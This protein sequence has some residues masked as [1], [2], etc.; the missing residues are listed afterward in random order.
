LLLATI[1]CS[2]GTILDTSAAFNSKF[3]AIE[4]GE[5]R[6]IEGELT[7]EWVSALLTDIANIPLGEKPRGLLVGIAKPTLKGAPWFV[8]RRAADAGGGSMASHWETTSR[9][10]GYG[11]ESA[12]AHIPS[13]AEG[14]TNAGAG[15]P[16]QVSNAGSDST[17]TYDNIIENPEPATLGLCAAAM[18]AMLFFRRKILG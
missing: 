13:H 18:G 15:S 8:P 5:L 14:S 17:D 2:A 12:A 9:E 7:F 11:T 6:L 10:L 16:S 4:S 1:P 3:S